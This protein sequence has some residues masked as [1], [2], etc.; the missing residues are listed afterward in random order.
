MAHVRL[1][2]CL[3]LWCV[4]SYSSTAFRL[5]TA[6]VSNAVRGLT[7]DFIVLPSARSA[8]GMNPAWV[9]AE[10]TSASL[11]AGA[12]VSVSVQ[13]ESDENGAELELSETDRTYLESQLAAE[14]KPSYQMALWCV[15]LVLGMM[16]FC[17]C[18]TCAVMFGSDGSQA[19]SHRES[20]SSFRT[21]RS[22]RSSVGSEGSRAP[23]EE[24]DAEDLLCRYL[25]AFSALQCET[26]MAL[27]ADDFTHVVNLKKAGV[28]GKGVTTL[29]GMPTFLTSFFTSLGRNSSYC[30]CDLDSLTA[31]NGDK[32]MALVKLRSLSTGPWTPCKVTVDTKGGKITKVCWDRSARIF[33]PDDGEQLN[34][35]ATGSG[36]ASPRSALASDRVERE[37]GQ[38][39]ATGQVS[40]SPSP[41]RK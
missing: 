35:S 6:A 31:I 8:R 38:P 26:L 7:S 2:R 18:Y 28:F 41:S 10:K 33:G 17:L 30:E 15:G 29:E 3:T 12:F 9:D 32:A 22:G 16:S 23:I 27:L 20:V 37:V 11:G 5:D 1:L 19:R 39:S 14:L 4:L 24:G 36:A 25:N 21:F 34:A 40:R 13:L